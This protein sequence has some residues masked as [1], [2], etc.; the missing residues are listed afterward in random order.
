M[1]H[2]PRSF[3]HIVINSNKWF[4]AVSEYALQFAMAL[5]DDGRQPLCLSH[6]GSP[7]FPK[8]EKAH[9]RASEL[10]LLGG[11]WGFVRSWTK[12]TKILRAE[13][14]VPRQPNP[15]SNGA[16]GVVDNFVDNS[17]THGVIWTFEGR[18]H[19]L[20]A[21]HRLIHRRTW[22]HW[23]LVRVRGQA[24]VVR[25]TWF[26]RWVYTRGADALV[27]AADV[28]RSRIPFAALLPALSVFPFCSRFSEA[29]LQSLHNVDRKTPIPFLQNTPSIDPSLPLFLVV[30]RFDPV[31]GHESLLRAF[32]DMAS[33]LPSNSPPVQL[34]FVG[35][36][37]N[38]HAHS[39]I[40]YAAQH[41]K[42]DVVSHGSRS[43]VK[44]VNGRAYLF[45]FDERLPNILELMS[46]AHFGVIPSLAS[47]VICRVAV[48]FMQ[49]GTPLVSSTAGA[50]AEIIPEDV[51]VFFS[52]GD[53]EDCRRALSEALS[54]AQAP[55]V[56]A[57]FRRDAL[58]AG[59][60]RYASWQYLSLVRELES[61]LFLRS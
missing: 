20:C 26:N 57:Q 53:E 48:E 4:S 16:A 15:R 55:G 7:L 42:G 18:E 22:E 6:P 5:R 44:G 38:V 39:L 58:A 51:G 11:V 24:A 17:A 56:L 2:A 8:Y 23:R 54:Y 31:K 21:L 10:P 60:E 46:K 29:S 35:R 37:E 43:F 25:N 61:C 52:P 36:S 45:L 30:G 27:A 59:V 34:V 28:V 13:R 3:A 47:E 40:S 19:T 50:L 12:L 49:S 33:R 9:L 32:G 1:A 41:W 14:G